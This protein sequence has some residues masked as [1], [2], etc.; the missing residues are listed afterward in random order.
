[1]YFNKKVEKKTDKKKK[2]W[3]QYIFSEKKKENDFLRAGFEP[4]T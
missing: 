4:A 1:M 3:G 2:K